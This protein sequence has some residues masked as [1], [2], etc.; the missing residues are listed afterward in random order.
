MRNRWGGIAFHFAGPVGRA[1]VNQTGLDIPGAFLHRRQDSA[2]AMNVSMKPPEKRNGT[3]IVLF[4][5]GLA[6]GTALGLGLAGTSFFTRKTS[7]PNAPD[8][9]AAVVTFREKA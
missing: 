7:A 4:V 6:T 1:R 9:G 2:K 3:R 8:D 5:L